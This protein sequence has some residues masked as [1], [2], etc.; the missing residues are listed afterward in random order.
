[1]K[2]G[3]PHKGIELMDGGEESVLGKAQEGRT[4]RKGQVGG[5]GA[6]RRGK[7]DKSGEREEALEKDRKE[8]Q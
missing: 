8:R 3:A 5:R 4:V 2:E 7:D 1:M 6:T